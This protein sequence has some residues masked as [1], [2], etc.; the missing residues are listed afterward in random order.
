M[1]TPNFIPRRGDVSPPRLNI[2]DERTPNDPEV[3]IVDN[4]SVC[5]AYYPFGNQPHGHHLQGAQ[6]DL[7]MA[8][9]GWNEQGRQL[10]Q[11][12]KNKDDIIKSR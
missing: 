9:W 4:D 2:N 10:R 8:I 5:A 12:D 11:E 7:D 6:D 1:K 3:R